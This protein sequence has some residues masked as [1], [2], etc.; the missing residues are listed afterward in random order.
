[1]KVISLDTPFIMRH[2]RGV[3]STFVFILGNWEVAVLRILGFLRTIQTPRCCVFSS[4]SSSTVDRVM[5]V[6]AL[7]TAKGKGGKK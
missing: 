7:K 6:P 4:S 5:K 1:M 2:E 3:F